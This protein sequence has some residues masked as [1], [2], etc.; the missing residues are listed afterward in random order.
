[1]DSNGLLI[2]LDLPTSKVDMEKR[3]RG[4]TEPRSVRWIT[5]N[6]HDPI[7][8][9]MVTQ[10]LEGNQIDLLFI[11]GGHTYESVKM[12]YEMYCPF[13]RS[14]GWIGFHDINSCSKEF[15]EVD[16]FWKERKGLK[17]EFNE[18]KDKNGIG[19]LRKE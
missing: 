10:A 19:I 9:S 12:D 3:E 16:R 17:F 7:T 18:Y 14:G 5:A 6:S 4:I 2:S 8:P 1:M 11:D 13:V 15:M